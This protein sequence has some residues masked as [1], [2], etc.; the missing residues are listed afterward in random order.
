MDPVSTSKQ[1]GGWLSSKSSIKGIDI[2]DISMDDS[3]NKNGKDNTPGN[4]YDN[5]ISI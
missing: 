2:E 3:S 5:H 4:D 1:P